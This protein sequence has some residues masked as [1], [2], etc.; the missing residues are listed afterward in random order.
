MDRLQKSKTRRDEVKEFRDAAALNI[1]DY[2]NPFEMDVGFTKN[3]LFTS[4]ADSFLLLC[5]E[6]HLA[7][8]V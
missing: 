5:V 6:I 4:E 3:S 2:S 8:E 1:L 7:I